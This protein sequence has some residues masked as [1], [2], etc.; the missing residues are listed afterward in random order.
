[1]TFMGHEPDATPAATWD[2]F[3]ARADSTKPASLRFVL[4][5]LK[6]LHLRWHNSNV[7][8][9]TRNARLDAHDARLDALEAQ[10]ARLTGDDV[11]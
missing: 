6:A 1:M 10:L 4:G 8:N 2:G 11:Q 3:I 9:T 7:M 5:A